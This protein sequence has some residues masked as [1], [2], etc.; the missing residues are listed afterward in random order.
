[1]FVL[2]SL[3]S[4][5][6][7]QSLCWHHSL[8]TEARSLCFN[9][10]LRFLPVLSCAV[11]TL[12][13]RLLFWK[14]MIF[15]PCL[16]CVHAVFVLTRPAH[17]E[18]AYQTLTFCCRSVFWRK[19]ACRAMKCKAALSC[20]RI[21]W[22]WSAHKNTSGVCES[23]GGISLDLLLPFRAD[24]AESQNNT[25]DFKQQIYWGSFLSW[26]NWILIEMH[27]WY[28]QRIFSAD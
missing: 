14:A 3:V 5:L 17:L 27:F 10:W 20:N 16:Q 18:P 6:I 13:L 28:R 25:V 12:I 9:I 7:F 15:C 24:Q 19:G 2:C 26:V 23:M 8:R 22:R 4:K 11:T 21:Q 1:M